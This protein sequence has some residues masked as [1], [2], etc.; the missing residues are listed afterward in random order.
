MLTSLAY[1]EWMDI[2]TLSGYFGVI[3][4]DFETLSDY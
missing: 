3:I 2:K 4:V 1:L